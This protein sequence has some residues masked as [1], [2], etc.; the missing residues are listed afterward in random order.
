MKKALVDLLFDSVDAIGTVDGFINERF[1]PVTQTLDSINPRVKYGLGMAS[2]L[3]FLYFDSYSQNP[4]Q[5]QIF[6]LMYSFLYCFPALGEG[7]HKGYKDKGGSRKITSP[8]TFSHNFFFTYS[9]M[10]WVTEG[11]GCLVA[12]FFVDD[13][14]YLRTVGLADFTFAAANYIVQSDDNEPR[15]PKRFFSRTRSLLENRSIATT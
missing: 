12:S 6:S 4:P 2:F 15:T 11:V 10:Y 9:R 1:R 7:D 14:N 8:V 3:D 5:N 13:P